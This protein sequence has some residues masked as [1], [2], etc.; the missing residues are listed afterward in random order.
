MYYNVQ[1]SRF[2]RKCARMKAVNFTEFR[3][4]ASAVLDLV[5]KGAIIRISR[6]GKTIAR[7][8]PEG[9][10]EPKMPWKR[11]GLWLTTKN[12]SLSKAILEERMSS[13]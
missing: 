7:I 8:V 6:H 4:N 10:Q 3:K 13:R 1:K 11:A 5:E 2:S 9:S 12:A